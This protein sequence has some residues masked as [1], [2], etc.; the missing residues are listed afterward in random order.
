MVIDSYQMF[1]VFSEIYW[2]PTTNLNTPKNLEE[3]KKEFSKDENLFFNHINSIPDQEFE[4]SRYMKE[5][6]EVI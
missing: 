6:I 1:R 5:W 4:Y 3:L 2:N